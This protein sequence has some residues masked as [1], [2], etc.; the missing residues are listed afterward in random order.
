MSL[1]Y[2][3]IHTSLAKG[4]KTADEI[5][6]EGRRAGLPYRDE[7]IRLFLR[8]SQEIHEQEGAWSCRI[9][10]KQGRILTALEKAFAAGGAY[11]PL[12]RLAQHL[13]EGEPVTQED[14][15]AACDESGR[16]R[17]QGRFILRS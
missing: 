5:V 9:A 4:P 7:T 2:E 6:A 8:L 14:I 12:D 11:L 16:Y 1:L 13:D 17:I 10:S 15:A 3:V